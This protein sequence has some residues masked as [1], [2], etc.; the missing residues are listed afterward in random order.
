MKKFFEDDGWNV[1]GC[2]WAWHALSRASEVSPKNLA[3]AP[4][5]HLPYE[6]NFFDSVV[7]RRTLHT[8]PADIRRQAIDECERVLKK[9]GTFICSVQNLN[10]KGTLRKYRKVGIELKDD[11]NSY[12]VDVIISG[13]RNQ[14]M[15][16]FYTKEDIT[17]EIEKN[18]KL[19]VQSVSEVTSQ[20][21]WCRDDQK[22]L[23]V[24]A[25]KVVD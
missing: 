20:A 9:G 6:D 5:E 16:H 21:G 2:D 8:N 13:K 15:K 22:Y 1:Y 7:S 14:R 11:K 3:Y 18:K 4:I 24:K 10:D 17:R 19:K 25:K 12:A 23:V